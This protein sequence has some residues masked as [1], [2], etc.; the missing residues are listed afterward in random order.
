[1]RI[2]I[3]GAGNVGTRLGIALFQ[4]N[5]I[6][7][8]VFSRSLERA[9]ALAEELSANATNQLSQIDDSADAVLFA[10]HD[11]AIRTIYLECQSQVSSKLLLHTAG[12]IPVSVFEPHARYGVLWP[13]QT[14]SAVHQIDMSGV[15]FVVSGNSDET[16]QEIDRVART[17]SPLIYHLNDAR[18]LK[19]HLCATLVNNFANQLYA[20]AD[21]MLAEDAI[22]F[23]ILE[24]IIRETADKVNRMAP[25]EAQT[26]AALRGDLVTMEKHLELLQDKP[27]LTTLYKL[28]SKRIREMHQ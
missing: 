18:R 4:S 26:G 5:H 28:L 24:P 11:D 16:I 22:P 20:E 14:L 27:E 25:G 10:V 9:Q 23:E 3:I 12:S 1:M 17:I 7:T 8:T 21:T 15:P 6:I 13:V 19:L 2:C